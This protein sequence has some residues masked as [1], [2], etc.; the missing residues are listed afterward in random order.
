M[1]LALSKEMGTDWKTMTQR[2]TVNNRC[3]KCYA[4]A[5]A[6]EGKQCAYRVTFVTDDGE[7]TLPMCDYASV[8]NRFLPEDFTIFL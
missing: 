8:S 3:K 2:P 5:I 1:L 7:E 4:E 6:A